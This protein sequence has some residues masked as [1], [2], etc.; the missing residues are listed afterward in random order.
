M[1]PRA[2]ASSLRRSWTASDGGTDV[3]SGPGLPR[4]EP[5]RWTYQRPFDLVD[6]DDAH[7]IVLA[8]YVTT[9]DGSGLVHQA[10]AF[11]ADDLAIS[12]SPRGQI[13]RRRWG[14]TT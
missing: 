14:R 12:R 3:P 5:E 13:S 2:V 10:P 8:T 6:L 9:E 4:K 7:Y 11:G 1:V